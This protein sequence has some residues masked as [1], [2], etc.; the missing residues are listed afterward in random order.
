MWKARLTDEPGREK[1][2]KEL[3]LNR[4]LRETERVYHEVLQEVRGE[5]KMKGKYGVA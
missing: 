5:R 2:L 1:A 4:M 3:T